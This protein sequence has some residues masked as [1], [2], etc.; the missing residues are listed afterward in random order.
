MISVK[1]V[2]QNY[3]NGRKKIEVKKEIK[4]LFELVE[5]AQFYYVMEHHFELEKAIER[6]KEIYNENGKVPLLLNFLKF[7][8]ENEAM[9]KKETKD[10]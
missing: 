8:V 10:I 5:D 4:Q 6:L 2:I 7:E 3:D 9:E 1:G